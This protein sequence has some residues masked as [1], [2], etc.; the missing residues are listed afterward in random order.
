MKVTIIL[1]T[2]RE[3]ESK[4][5]GYMAKMDEL[6]N[7]QMSEEMAVITLISEGLNAFNSRVRNKG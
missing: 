4:I 7:R 6:K 5:Y 1:E 2:S 3:L